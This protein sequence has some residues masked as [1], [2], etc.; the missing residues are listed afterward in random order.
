M[1]DV[2]AGP[3]PHDDPTRALVCSADS[4]GEVHV[5]ALEADGTWGHCTTF[6]C[7][8]VDGTPPLCTTARMRHTRLYCGYST[9]HVRVFDLVSW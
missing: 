9:G 3:A 2:T 6:G 5:H 4:A 7:A 8:T 1:V